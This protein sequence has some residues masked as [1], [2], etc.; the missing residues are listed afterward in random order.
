MKDLEETNIL[1]FEDPYSYR[2][3][4]S[5]TQGCYLVLMSKYQAVRLKTHRD[6]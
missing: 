3:G 6:H 5:K 1:P 4:P 2:S